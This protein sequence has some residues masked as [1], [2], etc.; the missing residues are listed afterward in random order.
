[1]LT[2]KQTAEMA[3]DRRE[4]NLGFLAR[5]RFDRHV[6]G[7]AGCR[8]FVRQL[9]VATRTVAL[10]PDP[11]ISPELSDAL[12]A[13]FDSL[14]A[15]GGVGSSIASRD[16]TPPTARVSP[17]AVVGAVT[18]L[19]LLLASGSSRSG[20]PEDWILG[21]LL[22]VAALAVAALSGRM[23]LGVVVAAV[24]AAFA[25]ALFGG[26]SGP[27]AADHGVACFSMEILS[28]LVVGGAAWFGSRGR[29]RGAVLR[30]VAGGAVAGALAANAAL[31]ITCGAHGS[32]PHLLAFHLGGVA[33][34]A[35]LAILVL[36]GRAAGAPT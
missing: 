32:M 17:W 6:N 7:C 25:A 24:A 20:A 16:R 35:G 18:V 14:T 5:L 9:D 10:L 1:M 34:I 11:D 28:A 23:A 15:M 30:T 4:G 19:G 31:Q 3:T 36:R 8:A 12:M 29:P 21:S 13:Q 33:F 26:T 27:L 2:C 22:A